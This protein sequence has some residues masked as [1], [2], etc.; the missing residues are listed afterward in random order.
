MVGVGVRSGRRDS[1]AAGSLVATGGMAGPVMVSY[2]AD[3]GGQHV[4]T[5][6]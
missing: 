4:L 5:I 2:T 3:T 6:G 1:D